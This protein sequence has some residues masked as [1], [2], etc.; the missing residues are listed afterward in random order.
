MAMNFS[1]PTLDTLSGV[2]GL[3]LFFI[4]PLWL[5]RWLERKA[6]PAMPPTK[7][8]AGVVV[9]AILALVLAVGFLV[10]SVFWL[11]SWPPRAFAQMKVRA[12]VAEQVK[13]LGGWEVVVRDCDQL[14]QRPDFQGFRWHS[15]S[16]I[17]RGPGSSSEPLPAGL[18]A[19]KPRSVRV[20]RYG[21]NQWMVD[22]FLHKPWPHGACGIR[23]ICD[24][25][26]N[27]PALL[28]GAHVPEVRN[29][30]QL[31]DRVYEF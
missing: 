5:I 16:M 2:L 17:H 20:A 8:V 6:E 1:S 10:S 26:T 27:A 24:A 25:P 15:P 3:L 12:V 18:V 9:R 31:A 19:L 4:L 13:E 21:T 7:S 14:I 29:G 28:Q 22:I 30:R 11:I 23:V